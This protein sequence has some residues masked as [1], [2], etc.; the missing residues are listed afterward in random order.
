MAK[1]FNPNK[2]EKNLDNFPKCFLTYSQISESVEFRLID[3]EKWVHSGPGGRISVISCVPVGRWLRIL[4]LT[5]NLTCLF[6]L[7]A[8]VDGLS[9]NI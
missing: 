3:Y 9:G 4:E 6:R 2:I 7:S 8:S 5:T 1:L